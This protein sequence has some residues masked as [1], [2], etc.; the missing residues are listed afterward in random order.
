MSSYKSIS[1]TVQERSFESQRPVD[2]FETQFTCFCFCLFKCYFRVLGS[3]SERKA[4]THLVNTF[5]NCILEWGTWRKGVRRSQRLGLFVDSRRIRQKVLL[6]HSRTSRSRDT[7]T[8]CCLWLVSII[9]LTF[10]ARKRKI[11]LINFSFFPVWKVSRSSDDSH[12]SLNPK[13]ARFWNIESQISEYL[14]F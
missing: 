7:M 4:D 5:G 9:Q 12:H 3:I 1:L 8:K 13:K 14:Q 11:K 2:R 6:M 10:G